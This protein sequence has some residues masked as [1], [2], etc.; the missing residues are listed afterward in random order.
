[1]YSSA[2][3]VDGYTS[4]KG[5]DFMHLGMRVVQSIDDG[6]VAISQEAYVSE[7]IQQAGPMIAKF[8][9]KRGTT[10]S[11]P[12]IF[13]NDDSTPMLSED[14]RDS[15][16]SLN[17]SLMFASTRTC[18]ETLVTATACAS[19][20][21]KASE[22][23][24][25][26]LLKAI[27]YLGKDKERCLTIRPG[28]ERIVCSADCSYASHADG[29]SHTG[30]ALGFAGAGGIPDSFCVFAS[31]KQTTVTKSSCHG[32]LTAANVGAD[33]IVWARQLLEGFGVG[34]A[35]SR[36]VRKGT[37][38]GELVTDVGPSIL[39]QDNKSTIHL[40]VMGRG[41]YRNSKHI[42]VRECFIRDLVRDREIDVEWQ[43]TSLMVADMLTKGVTGTVFDTLLPALVGRRKGCVA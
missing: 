13:H 32:E 30:V 34:D 19:R 8:G 6:S 24:M 31:G 29:Y 16:R 22:G 17:M 28:S 39:R 21:V 3:G 11:D 4:E 33:Y 41:S 7:L 14:D 40:I 37:G 18:P 35:P 36:L 20:I 38:E 42:R 12:D 25:R 15:Y 2:F 5:D 1:M 26:R 9:V 23:D 27:V 10:P 43:H